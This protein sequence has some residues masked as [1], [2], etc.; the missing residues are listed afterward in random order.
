MPSTNLFEDFW[1]MLAVRN[2]CWFFLMQVFHTCEFWAMNVC[3]FMAL[4][5][6]RVPLFERNQLEPGMQSIRHF[7]AES[8]QVL[9]GKHAAMQCFCKSSGRGWLTWPF[10]NLSEAFS[11]Q[12]YQGSRG[13]GS[14]LRGRIFLGLEVHLI[15]KAVCEY[16]LIFIYILYIYKIDIFSQS[17]TIEVPWVIFSLYAFLCAFASTKK[18]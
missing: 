18:D 5:S 2:Q 17:F 7:R 6:A 9:D 12:T 8:F 3:V 13:V 15:V 16:G 10:E 1:S 4:C 11:Q 14:W